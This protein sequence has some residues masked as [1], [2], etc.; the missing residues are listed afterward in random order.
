MK[1]Q[2][3]NLIKLIGV[4]VLFAVFLVMMYTFY[5]AYNNPSKSV[6]VYI[7]KRGEAN[8][9]AWLIFPFVFLAGFSALIIIMKETAITTKKKNMG[10][11]KYQE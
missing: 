4:F 7:N 2:N 8:I 1:Q 10:R 11:R 3:K 9:E 6:V 5:T